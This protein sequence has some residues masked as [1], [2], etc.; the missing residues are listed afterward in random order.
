MY[1]SFLAVIHCKNQPWPLTFFTLTFSRSSTI[2]PLAQVI[3][4]IY[5]TTPG[6][7]DVFDEE[8]FYAF[9]AVITVLSFVAA[10]VASR[11][12]T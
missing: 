5:D 8:T 7:S 1:N 9:F 6:F 3:D 10:F 4:K 12:V 11:C 2:P